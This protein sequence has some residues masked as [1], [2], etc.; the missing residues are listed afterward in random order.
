MIVP[1][2]RV[3]L[4]CL[5]DQ[6]ETALEGLRQVGLL[7]V[8]AADN[9]VAADTAAL[10][11]AC[12]SLADALAWLDA[13]VDTAPGPATAGSGAETLV[14]QL[15]ALRAE[16]RG[17]D[18]S[19]QALNTERQRLAPFGPV[20]PQQFATLA[21]RG[22]PVTLF[23]AELKLPLPEITDG[24]L[25]L[26]SEDAFARYGVIVGSV[27][28]DAQITPLAAPERSTAELDT[29]IATHAERRD[30]LS[31]ELA[32]LALARPVMQAHLRELNDQRALAET[33]DGMGT[34]RAVAYLTGYCPTPDLTRLNNAAR[35]QGWGLLVEEP[36]AEESV[37][38]LLEHPAWIQPIKAV[39]DML[40]ISPGYREADI[41]GIFLA[42]FSVFFGILIGDAGY[43][44]LILI[45]T[46]IVQRKMRDAPTYPFTL[47]KI[48]SMTTIAWGVLTANYFG[49]LFDA[50]P[51]L[52]QG[53]RVDWL[54]E[55]NNLMGLCFLIGALHLSLAHV[56]NA[57]ILFPHRKAYAQAGWMCMVWTMYF[58]ACSMVLQRP[59]PLFAGVL[60]AA[61][62]GLIIAFMT[63]PADFKRDWIDHAMLPLS[64]VSCL[65]DVISYIRLFAVGMAAVKVAESFNGMAVGMGLPLVVQVPVAALILLLGHGL[66]IVLGALGILVHAVRLNTL[67]FSQHKGLAWAGIAY[68]PFKKD[69][70]QEN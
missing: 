8:A 50:L 62:L 33:R 35:A 47:F 25:Q 17:L 20:D 29:A 51:P 9:P 27:P 69:T 48:L 24:Y 39:F 42:F 52:L 60:G 21:T 15:M 56:W 19:L 34:D 32:A 7:H 45:A 26:L 53:W 10:Q 16:R 31:S 28:D 6:R 66:N 2:K 36:G 43:G 55:Q 3:T 11:H 18:E 41:G 59:F 61:G 14:E 58:V 5:R 1:M 57:I 38:T 65:V 13:E 12:E 44:A 46:L 4:L 49:I 67:E 30:A 23:R 63:E 64:L 37:P 40:G 70:Y 68:K 54:A 22:L